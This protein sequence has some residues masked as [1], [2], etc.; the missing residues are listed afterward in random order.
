M[1]GEERQTFLSIIEQDK[2]GVQESLLLSLGF[3]GLNV[4]LS[5]GIFS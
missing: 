1:G 3:E 5:T 4:L 2:M